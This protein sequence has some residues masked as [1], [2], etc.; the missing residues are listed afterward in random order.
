MKIFKDKTVYSW[1]EDLE[2]GVSWWLEPPVELLDRLGLLVSPTE[3]FIAN[4]IDTD[5]GL[6]LVDPRLASNYELVK[7]I[8][9]CEDLDLIREIVEPFIQ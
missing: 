5:Q 9:T 3:S 8:A 6:L 7:L 2:H 4:I 1:V